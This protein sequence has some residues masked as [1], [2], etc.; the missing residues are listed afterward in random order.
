[1]MRFARGFV[2]VSVTAG[3]A[4]LFSDCKK[5]TTPTPVPTTPP[6]V[7]AVIAS[8]SFTGFPPD[9]YLGIPIPLGQ[10]GI[11][12]FTVDWTFK[13]TYMDVA[14]GT[15]ACSFAELNTKKCPFVT[16]TEGTTPKPR[17]VT[18]QLLP[19]GQYY[20][21]L[22]SQPYSKKLGY[23]SDNLEAVALQIG[24]TVG[25]TGS[26]QPVTPIKL[27]SQFITR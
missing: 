24:L 15:Q 20:L 1:M 7:H 17:I 23:G 6:L 25:I 26:A 27:Q 18:T 9:I 21:Y 22:Y 16:F 8:T 11:L 13:D 2:L 12:D 5:S 19:V 4:L 3:G 10:A 14:F